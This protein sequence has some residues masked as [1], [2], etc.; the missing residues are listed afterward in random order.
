[1]ENDFERSP[2]RN[3]M[4]NEVVSSMVISFLKILIGIRKEN[5]LFRVGED[6]KKHLISNCRKKYLSIQEVY[7]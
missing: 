1:M 4:D 2:K 6:F 3:H 5:F 7:F